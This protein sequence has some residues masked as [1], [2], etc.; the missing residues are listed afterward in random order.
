[1]RVLLVDDND[2]VRTGLRQMLE[3]QDDIE[4]VGEGRNGVE[5]ITGADR[6]RPD[7]VIMDMNMPVMNGV[8]ATEMIKRTHPEVRVLALTAYA[9]MS[10]VS[11]MVKAG[12]D[13]YLL[14]GAP[15]KELVQSLRSVAGG[16]GAI[17]NEIAHDVMDD[18]ADLYRKEKEHA[19]ALAELDRMKS[20]FISIV[21]HELRTPLTTI[22][23]GVSLMR[24][25]WDDLNDD[26]KL[27]LLD[28]MT[29]Q[30]LRL[31]RMVTQIVTVAGIQ[32][33]FSVHASE[34]ALREVAEAA[35]TELSSV[36]A[37]RDISLQLADVGARGDRDLVKQASVTLIENALVFTSGTVTVEL[38][39]RLGRAHLQVRD[40]GPGIAESTLRTLI[41][42]PFV[43]GDSSS[44]R[45]AG[46]LGLSLYIA[47]QVLRASGGEL[48]IDTGPERGST[49]T[50]VL[51]AA[52]VRS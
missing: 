41:D 43:Q 44:T 15:S 1:M 27:Q 51:P 10:L 42:E 11:G 32:G 36:T 31:E 19:A 8:E 3:I 39:G 5:A 52:P 33:G 26:L 18:M 45:R 14:K 34:F 48:E 46:G 22:S 28:S 37:G 21:S 24:G 30:C 35:L 38:F 6:H 13:G 25:R 40:E 16:Q 2:P 4:V 20:E 29:K 49:F 12:A 47:R 7:I 17:A 23:G 50:M 9:E